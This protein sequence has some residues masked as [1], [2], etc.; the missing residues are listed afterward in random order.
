MKIRDIRLH[1]LPDIP[2]PMMIA[3]VTAHLLVRT[4]LH[5]GKP[6]IR[7]VWRR[8]KTAC[9]ALAT[10]LLLRSTTSYTAGGHPRQER[11]R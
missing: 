8:S 4:L 2:E 5:K 6:R 11:Q 3:L 7:S 1:S 9:D 10:A